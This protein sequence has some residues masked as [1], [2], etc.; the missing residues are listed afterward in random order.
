MVCA[1]AAAARLNLPAT[2]LVETANHDEITTATLRK[3]LDDTS[4][5]ILEWLWSS[6]TAF[7]KARPSGAVNRSN[8][9]RCTGCEGLFSNTTVQPNGIISPCCGLGIRFVPELQIGRMGVDSLEE[10]VRSAGQDTLKRRIREEGPE[11]I[12]AWAAARDPR[13]QWEDLYAHRCQACIRLHK[14]PLVREVLAACDGG[15]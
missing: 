9:D 3:R 4:V 12:L 11:R 10:A 6:L 15:N 8:L 7:P 13:I 2:V 14:D 1:A 5:R